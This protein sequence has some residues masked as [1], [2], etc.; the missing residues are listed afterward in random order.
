MTAHPVRFFLL[1]AALLS[2]AACAHDGKLTLAEG[3]PPAAACH[4]RPFEGEDGPSPIS[5]FGCATEANLRAMIIDSRDLEQGADLPAPSGDAAVAAAR[6][7]RL[8]EVKPLVAAVAPA[9]GF[10]AHPEGN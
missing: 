6:R 8:G 4:A 5:G 3:P 9:A 2:L 7:H 1:P 10:A